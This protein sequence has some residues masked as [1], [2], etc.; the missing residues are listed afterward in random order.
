M[1][2]R[3]VDVPE[4]HYE[5]E[6]M[7]ATVVPNRNAIFSSLAYGYALSLA[8]RSEGRIQLALGVHSGDH[9]IYPDCR[10][11]FYEALDKAFRMG[12]WESDRINFY[13]PFLQGDKLTI[14]QDA[15]RSIKKLPGVDFDEIFKNTNTSYNPDERGR[16]SGKSGADVE[17]ILAFHELGRPDPVE[18]VKPWEEVLADALKV[19]E[20]HEAVSGGS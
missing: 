17:R 3:S 19:K 10:P 11:D 2:D 1:T 8:G 7:K 4:G 9:A 12:N 20:E 14:L 6:N 15:E 18:Y 13:L 16:S 5:Q